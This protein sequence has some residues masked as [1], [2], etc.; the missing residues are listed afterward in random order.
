M[1]AIRKVWNAITPVLSQIIK[2]VVVI[3][4]L[5]KNSGFVPTGSKAETWIDLAIDEFTG[6]TTIVVPLTEKIN[7]LLNSF[8]TEGEKDAAVFK[9]ASIASKI[10]HIETGEELNTTFIYDSA[11]QLRIIAD[12]QA[13]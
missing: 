13:L 5:I 2:D 10:G 12:K 1:P 6:V 7:D 3:T 11:V 9:I 4:G 8:T